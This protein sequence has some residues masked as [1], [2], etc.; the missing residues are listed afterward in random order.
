MPDQVR[1][2][3][4]RL[5][6]R[7]V[8]IMRMR[9]AN[10]Y[11]RAKVVATLGPASSE[12]EMISELII[13]GMNV[14][15]VNMS[16][17]SPRECAQLISNIRKASSLV[18]LEVA[19]LMDLQ[20]PKIRV[21][22]LTNGLKLKK[23]DFW[24]I[25]P[26]DLQKDYPEYKD[27]FIPTTYKHLT[28]D[29]E[30]GVRILFDDGLIT[31]HA[32]ERDR[33][34]YKIKVIV[35]GILKSNKGINLP[36][37]RVS[38]PSLTE[39]D[40]K[41]LMFG[42]EHDVDYIALSF[43]RKK[44]DIL[45]LK[46][47]LQEHNKDIPVVSKIENPEAL[48]NIEE[49]LS[50][51]DVVMVARGD[52]GVELGNHLVPAAQKKIISL[53]NNRGIPVITATQML[54]ARIESPVPTRAEASDVA[55]AVWDGTDAAMLSAETASGKYPIEAVR[56]MG[57]II[58]EAEK[59]PKERPSL[60]VMDL[61]QVDNA[62]MIGASI[63]AE[64]IDAKRILSVTNSGSSCLKMSR[65]RPQTSVL[66]V[67]H[68]LSVVRKMC[69]YWG[70]SP[71]YLDEYDEDNRELE[72]YVIEKVRSACELETGDKIVI[73]RGSGKFFLRGSSNSI[74]VETIR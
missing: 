26:T 9:R 73:T 35:G 72:H 16:H 46:G 11:R 29:C 70:V 40:L 57:K 65:F 45:M 62:T 71:L 69:L 13:A 61:T 67:S 74:K 31:A 51:T 43:V 66:G 54:E 50:V 44:E 42:L 24:V 41:D 3:G 14:A 15:R 20:G 47:L 17:G 37:S 38:A 56:M 36:D 55:N 64:K 22:K 32:V 34:V 63:I 23:G 49:I 2:D 52:M 4:V 58:S 28:D 53:C 30:D 25:G 48:E 6:S 39:K 21:D 10:L 60:K 18:G 27:C 19:I 5:F 59:T 33:H 68:S 8:N 12:V 1:H 7:Q